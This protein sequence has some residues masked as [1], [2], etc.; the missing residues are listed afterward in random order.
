M[1]REFFVTQKAIVS[2][3][4]SAPTE[5]DFNTLNENK[6]SSKNLSQVP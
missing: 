4:V 3:Y 6:K 5:I 2:S 1:L